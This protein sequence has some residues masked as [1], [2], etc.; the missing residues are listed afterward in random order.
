MSLHVLALEDLNECDLLPGRRSRNR[1]LKDPPR[2]QTQSVGP[3]LK[4][5]CAAQRA[6][7]C[8]SEVVAD[9]MNCVAGRQAGCRQAG[10]QAGCRTRG[11]QGCG[12]NFTMSGV[13]LL[14]NPDFTPRPGVKLFRIP[15]FTL[16]P[17]RKATANS[18]FTPKS[19]V[20]KPRFL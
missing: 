9:S 18:D 4:R 10:R 8:K 2:H 3:D 11:S 20:R 14:R 15:D 6:P 17:W 16:G 19:G 12:S 13:K 1:T 5:E 7:I